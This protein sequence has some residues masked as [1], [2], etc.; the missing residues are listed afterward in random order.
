MYFLSVKIDDNNNGIP[1][2]SEHSDDM[3]N[4]VGLAENMFE[5]LTRHKSW[6]RPVI[7]NNFNAKR[8]SDAAMDVVEEKSV[9]FDWS[10]VDKYD[11]TIRCYITRNV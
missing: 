9:D 4:L 7:D 3:A 1:L 8:M 10:Y 6:D 5:M 11:R 2:I